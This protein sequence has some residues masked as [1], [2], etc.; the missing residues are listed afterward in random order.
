MLL[1]N[2]YLLLLSA[3][4]AS[5]TPLA[6]TETASWGVYTCAEKNYGRNSSQ[7][8]CIWVD[9]PSLGPDACYTSDFW[10]RSFG[11]DK[12]VQCRLVSRVSSL[13]KKHAEVRSSRKAARASEWAS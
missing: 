4:I 12:G 7:P 1:L 3:A 13:C 9:W 10:M 11:P 2:A 5:S 8:H 6:Q